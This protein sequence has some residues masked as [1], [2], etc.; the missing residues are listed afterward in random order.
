M[1]DDEAHAVQLGEL[2]DGR[3]VIVNLI[4]FVTPRTRPRGTRPRRARPARAAMA[5]VLAG[6][7]FRLRTTVRKEMGQD[8]AGACGQLALDASAWEASARARNLERPGGA[9]RKRRRA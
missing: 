8:I 6:P 2:L 1:N 5:A 4:P 3:D 9:R 7:K